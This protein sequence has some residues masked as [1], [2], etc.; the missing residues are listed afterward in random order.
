MEALVKQK[1]SEGLSEIRKKVK[2]IVRSEEMDSMQKWSSLSGEDISEF[3]RSL[4]AIELDLE[5]E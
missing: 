1:K 3:M 2:D 5:N 4:I